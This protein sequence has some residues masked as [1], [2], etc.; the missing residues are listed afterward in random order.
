MV[1]RGWGSRTH[2]RRPGSLLWLPA[3]LSK[4]QVEKKKPRQDSDILWFGGAEDIPE[5]GR[6]LCP[7]KACRPPA[8][9]DNEPGEAAAPAVLPRAQ[10]RLAIVPGPLGE[11]LQAQISP[12]RAADAA[13]S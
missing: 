9:P 13:R 7:H 12:A 1:P 8:A 2:R 6:D 10:Q 4:M 11:L 3:C 5:S